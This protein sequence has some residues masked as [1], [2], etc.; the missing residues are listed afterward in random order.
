MTNK[1]RSRAFGLDWRWQVS[2]I[3][4]GPQSTLWHL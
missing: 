2:P 4:V 1:H 3:L